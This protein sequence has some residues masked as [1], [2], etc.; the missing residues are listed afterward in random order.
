MR[1]LTSPDMRVKRASVSAVA[2][3]IAPT[4]ATT[5]VP[6]ALVEQFR[7]GCRC[8][9]ETLFAQLSDPIEATIRRLLGWPTD[10]NDEIDD[11]VQNVL[12]AAWEHRRKFRG[13]SS[14][15]TWITRIAINECRRAQRRRWIER[16]WWRR[17]TAT[18][19]NGAEIDT[20]SKCDDRLMRQETAARVRAAIQELA[21]RQREVIVLYYLEGLKARE[22]AEVLGVKQGT[23]EVRLT[24][25][26]QR[27]A[28]CLGDAS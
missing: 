16:K 15:K 22:I 12:L 11:L 5:D 2:T 23:V 9:T 6:S 19:V 8:S 24:R 4:V 14:I 13:N 28:E 27:L 17:V 26:R 25:A 3:T 18:G 7:L 21:T 1:T 10:A 20:T